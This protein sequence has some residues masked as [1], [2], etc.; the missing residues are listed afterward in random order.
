MSNKKE[1]KRLSYAERLKI[2][3]LVKSG[4]NAVDIAKVLDR[5]PASIY[6]ELKRSSEP[7]SAEEAQKSL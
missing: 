3:R 2:E 4:F 6:R 7:Y 5:T 1:W